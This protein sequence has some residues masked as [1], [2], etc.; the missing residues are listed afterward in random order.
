MVATLPMSR[1]GAHFDPTPAELPELPQSARERGRLW[2]DA[3]FRAVAALQRQLTHRDADI[4]AAA[5]NSILELERTRMRH[6]TLLAGSEEVS[7][8]QL[9]FEEEERRES[10]MSAR[11]RAAG[12]ATDEPVETAPAEGTRSNEQALAEHVLE[13]T[14]YSERADRPHAVPPA[15]FVP[16]ALKRWGLPANA[17]PDGGFFA[18]LRKHGVAEK[19]GVAR[20]RSSLQ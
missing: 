5:A 12:S 6:S 18:H 9:Q 8:A 19:P 16:W 2:S 7:E 13:M 17:I 11:R 4:V 14:E 20:L 15:Q 10:E 3:V 1:I